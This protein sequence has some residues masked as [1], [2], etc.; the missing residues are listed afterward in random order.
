VNTNPNKDAEVAVDVPGVTI[1]SVKGRVLTAPAIDTHNTF[2]APD[3]IKPAP[4]SANAG[5]DG[6]LTIKIPSKAV[7]VVA[8]E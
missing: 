6:R 5:A 1:K 4:F 7:I 2:Q 8:V 3:T